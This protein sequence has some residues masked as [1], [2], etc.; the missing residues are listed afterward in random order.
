MQAGIARVRELADSG[1]Y[2]EALEGCDLLVG[3]APHLEQ[4]RRL[5]QEVREAARQAGLGSPPDEPEPSTAPT[6]GGIEAILSAARDALAAGRIQEAAAAAAKALVLDPSNME[7][8]G[9]LSLAGDGAAVVGAEPAI[10]A[11]GDALYHMADTGPIQ[12]VPQVPEP[13][14]ERDEPGNAGKAAAG[15]VLESPAPDTL[16][17]DLDLDGALMTQPV[18]SVRPAVGDHPARKERGDRIAALIREGQARFDEGGYEAAIEAWS[19]IFAIDQANSEAGALIDR[20][21]STIEEHAR[22]VDGLFFK[23]MDARDAGRNEAALETLQEV[24]TLSPGHV[25]ALAAILEIKNGPGSSDATGA[26]HDADAET[27]VEP[28]KALSKERLFEEPTVPLAIPTK[29]DS[30]RRSTQLD[31]APARA[32]GARGGRSGRLLVVTMGVL[33]LALAAGAAY[34]WF[35][36]SGGSTGDP[37]VAAVVPEPAPTGTAPQSEPASSDPIDPVTG[38]TPAGVGKA[39]SGTDPHELQRQAA[40]LEE[41]GRRLFE[42]KNWA[43]AVI[44]LKRSMQLDAVYFRSEDLLSEA[45]EELEKQARFERDMDLAAKAFTE[46]DYGTA[47][48]KLYRLQQDSGEKKSFDRYIRNA[49]FNWGLTALMSGH[50]EEAG[51]KLREALEIDPDDREASRVLEMAGRYRLRRPDQVLDS[52]TSSIPLRSLDQR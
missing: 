33:G 14:Q 19:R 24:L 51:E 2:A 50:A 44:A 43:E 27:A 35:Q 30:P 20:A 49:W 25:E 8:T 47:L 17:A 3:L 15:G 4:V 48:H 42:Q 9:I 12:V 38:S 23:A 52:F 11:A 13:I 46:G 41:R 5:C 18:E 45:I 21:K 39:G 22:Q 28:P 7:A 37:V 26:A 40:A 1:K 6:G 36:R 32:R 10:A 34:W 29:K 31:G 16:I